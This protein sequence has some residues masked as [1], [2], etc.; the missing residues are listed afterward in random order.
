MDGPADLFDQTTDS[1]TTD[2]L[3]D[4]Y[5][6]QILRAMPCY[7]CKRAEVFCHRVTIFIS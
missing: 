7:I 1:R 2:L 4:S 5:A 6:E 3:N